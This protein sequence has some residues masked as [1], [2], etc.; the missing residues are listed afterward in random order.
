MSAVCPSIGPCWIL[1]TRV[2]LQKPA[3]SAV[4]LAVGMP[5]LS[6]S[7]DSWVGVHVSVIFGLA[8][9]SLPGSSGCCMALVVLSY[10]FGLPEPIGESLDHGLVPD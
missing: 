4:P 6:G 8:V 7:S 10:L 9:R 1:G 2:S 5:F 3:L